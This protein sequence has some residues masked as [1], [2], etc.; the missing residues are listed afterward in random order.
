M[1]LTLSLVACGGGGGGGGGVTPP[2][3]STAANVQLQP[4][5]IGAGQSIVD[6]TVSL[7]TR[8]EPGPALLQGTLV[9][10]P[11]LRLPT[12]DRLAPATAMVTLDG[13]FTNASITN[14]EFK[15]IC[16]DATNPQA[17]DLPLGAL[18]HVRL[19]P[20]A[21]RQPGTYTVTFNDLRAAS[22]DG[23]NVPLALTSLTATVTIQ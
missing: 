9:L 23:S 6:L 20:M 22:S 2:P 5:T 13:D 3:I 1:L 21:P 18:F 10:P 15:V 14:N 8:T 12:S 7:A 16:G 4:V 11:E 17:Q 19:M